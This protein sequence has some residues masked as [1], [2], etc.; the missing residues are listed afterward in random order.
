MSASKKAKYSPSIADL[1][2]TKRLDHFVAECDRVEWRR[3][4]G[5]PL[6]CCD[7]CVTDRRPNM[8]R[9]EKPLLY[10]VD[11][12]TDW[13]RKQ[14]PDYSR[15]ARPMFRPRVESAL[16]SYIRRHPDRDFDREIVDSESSA[17]IDGGDVVDTANIL[18]SSMRATYSSS[19]SSVAATA[20]VAAAG[21]GA[22]TSTTPS[23]IGAPSVGVTPIRFPSIDDAAPPTSNNGVA[24]SVFA[25]AMTTGGPV[26]VDDTDELAT[27]IDDDDDAADATATSSTTP[28][29]RV[30]EKDGERKRKR[31]AARTKRA[32]DLGTTRS[33]AT[34]LLGVVALACVR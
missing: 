32:N 10:D 28:P 15:Q 1:Q 17:D 21:S 18:N 11:L 14:Y 13:L 2:M 3:S 16:I 30:H 29:R 9:R 5:A 33:C 24:S 27:T 12:V 8:Q 4:V 31:A 6:A 19:S 25:G 7:E 22:L 34:T 26:L 23:A 20:A